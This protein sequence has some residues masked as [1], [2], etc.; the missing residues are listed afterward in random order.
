MPLPLLMLMALIATVSSERII[1]R[2]IYDSVEGCQIHWDTGKG[3]A[4]TGERCLSMHQESKYNANTTLSTCIKAGFNTEAGNCFVMYSQSCPKIYGS[5]NAGETA[6]MGEC[7]DAIK[8]NTAPLNVSADTCSPPSSQKALNASVSNN[9]TLGGRPAVPPEAPSTV[10]MNSTASSS[11]PIRDT[12]V[13]QGMQAMPKTMDVGMI[14]GLAAGGLALV[15]TL[16]LAAMWLCKRRAAA[17]QQQ[18]LKGILQNSSAAPSAGLPVV[19]ATPVDSDSFSGPLHCIA[20]YDVTPAMN[21]GMS[22]PASCYTRSSYS[23][24]M[25][26]TSSSQ[27][28]QSIMKKLPSTQM[29]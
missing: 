8:D 6:W 18:H 19:M 21:R 22:T 15:T 1:T 16:F 28:S 27:S 26:T 3:T 20:I 14:A 10:F 4:V 29:I 2:C 9:I 25:N 5:I 7:S 23:S 12:P 11:I 17:A 24:S 13:A